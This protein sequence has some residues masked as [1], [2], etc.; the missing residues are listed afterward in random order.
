[1]SEQKTS[2]WAQLKAA[3]ERANNKAKAIQGKATAIGREVITTAEVLGAS[4]VAGFVDERWG[5]AD[6]T[7]GL[8]TLMVGNVPA[9]LVGAAALKGAGAFEVF[10]EYSRDAFALGSGVGA[11]WSSA[12]GRSSAIRFAARQ[13]EKAAEVAEPTKAKKVA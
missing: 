10:G 1:M 12:A 3:A 6:A 13:A 2:T 11:N 9:S 5:V 7:T 4:F 8:K